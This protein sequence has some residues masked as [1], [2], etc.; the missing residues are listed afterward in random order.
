MDVLLMASEVGQVLGGAQNLGIAPA[1]ALLPFSLPPLPTNG[2][3]GWLPML[4][5]HLITQGAFLSPT[6]T[7]TSCN[8]QLAIPSNAK[9]QLPVPSGA[10]SAGCPTI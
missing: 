10:S 4:S 9:P 7:G 3:G 5:L 8:T 1:P 6:P 2:V